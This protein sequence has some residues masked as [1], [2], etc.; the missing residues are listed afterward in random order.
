[1]KHSLYLLFFF[2]AA[3]QT[4]TPEQK[5][6]EIHKQT[7]TLDTHIDFDTKDFSKHRHYGQDLDTQVNMV[8]MEK[9]KLDAGFFIVYTGQGKLDKKG[10]AKAHKQAMAKFD[11]IKRMTTELVPE[12]ISLAVTPEQV[13]KI[14]KSGKKV[15]MIGVENA[16]PLGEDLKNLEDFYNR[17][18]RYVSIN[19]NGHNQFGDSNVPKAWDKKIK[20]NG[21]SRLG[22]KL[23]KESNRL[24]IMVDISHAAQK[25]AQDVIKISKAPI[26]AS[27]SSVQGVYD[28]PRNLSDKT[29]MALK[30]NGGVVQIV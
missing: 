18:A 27:H 4:M 21:L 13:R 23:V 30:E 15:A 25:T 1:M 28:H 5:A 12:K 9:G 16:Y 10:Y 11:A 24:G 29:L 20:Y 17:G 26:I 8:K 7:L 19:H 14:W 3:C 2:F 6:D 22:E